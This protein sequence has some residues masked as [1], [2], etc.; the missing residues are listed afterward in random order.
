MFD[1]WSTR[2]KSFTFYCY[3]LCKNVNMK[4]II[5]QEINFNN[6]TDKV[7]CR[8]QLRINQLSFESSIEL[9]FSCLNRLLGYIGRHLNGVS[10]FDLIKEDQL[11]NDIYYSLMLNDFNIKEI[12]LEALALMGAHPLKISA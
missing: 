8:G 12:N 1:T 7:V 11:G 9:T 2:R 10:I 4:T 5:I 3:N 6:H